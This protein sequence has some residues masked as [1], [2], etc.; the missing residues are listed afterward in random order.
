MAIQNILIVDDSKTETMFLAEL[1]QKNGYVV[2]SA[3]NAEAAMACLLQNRPDLILMDVVMPGQNGFQLTRT[4]SRTPAYADIPIIL[5]TSKS[6]ETDRVWG[7]RQGA[8]AYL[9]KPLDTTDLLT[10]IRML[11]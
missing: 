3:E 4:I 11:G 9:T 7:M 6:Q 5:C 1:L 2:Q 8:S 10:K